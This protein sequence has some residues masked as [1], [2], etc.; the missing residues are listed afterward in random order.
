MYPDILDKW[1]YHEGVN[2]TYVLS[3][4]NIEKL[5]TSR[6]IFLNPKVEG[7][8]DITNYKA[9]TDFIK[10]SKLDLSTIRPELQIKMREEYERF[11]IL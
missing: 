9:F 4:K 8:Q 10:G 2:E 11:M 3:K 5:N 7:K 6:I 1:G